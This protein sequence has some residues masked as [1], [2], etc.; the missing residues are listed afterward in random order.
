MLTTK[1]RKKLHY[2]FILELFFSHKISNPRK[3]YRGHQLV[4]RIMN[5]LVVLKTTLFVACVKLMAI[6]IKTTEMRKLLKITDNLLTY[7]H[8]WRK[9]LL[10]SSHRGTLSSWTVR[11]D[12][13]QLDLEMRT[14]YFWKLVII[15]KVQR[16]YYAF[17]FA[18]VINILL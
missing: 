9:A 15:L 11:C 1:L 2:Y 8:L 4:L 17:R 12:A 3:R 16:R 13:A 18:L 6:M 14:S 7:V 10:V 5:T